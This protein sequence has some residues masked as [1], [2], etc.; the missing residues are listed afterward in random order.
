MPKRRSR[1]RRWPPGSG[2][3]LFFWNKGY[4]VYLVVGNHF[5]TR[6]YNYGTLL[7]SGFKDQGLSLF[8]TFWPSGQEFWYNVSAF[9]GS[10]AILIWECMD[11]PSWEFHFWISW[12]W[13]ILDTSS[14]HCC[15]TWSLKELSTS[16]LFL[17]FASPFCNLPRFSPTV[18]DDTGYGIVVC[19]IVRESGNSQVRQGPALW[20]W[21]RIPEGILLWRNCGYQHIE[22]TSFDAGGQGYKLLEPCHL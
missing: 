14:F 19:E 7:I 13:H 16:L 17:L 6:W 15:F 20:H 1:G 10:G 21:S 5:Q 22:C 3:D 11:L 9:L 18:G 4:R 8:G 2:K 12:S